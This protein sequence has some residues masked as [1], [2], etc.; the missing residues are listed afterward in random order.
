[1]NFSYF[2]YLYISLIIKYNKKELKK[3]GEWCGIQFLER[4]KYE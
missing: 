2:F 4:K 1:M 3:I